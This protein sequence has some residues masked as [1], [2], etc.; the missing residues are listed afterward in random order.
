[1]SRILIVDD[2]TI[3]RRN[4]KTILQKAGHTVVAEADNG[5][6]AVREY[7]LHKPD[8]V[9][10]DIT[11]P[12]MD[13]VAA[14]RKITEEFPDANII[15]ISAIDQ[16]PMIMK[17]VEAGAKHYILKPFQPEKVLAAV[18]LVTGNLPGK[19]QA[20]IMGHRGFA[21]ASVQD[22]EPFRIENRNGA[23]IVN[24]SQYFVSD[25]V[26]L[27]VDKTNPLLQAKPLRMIFDFG[28]T[29][30]KDTSLMPLLSQLI[31]SV[32]DAGGLVLAKTSDQ[33]LANFLES[34]GIN[35]N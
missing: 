23:F 2:S 16:K 13:G 9:T 1:M 19:A 4:L 8:L 14:V 28:N 34:Q 27:L 24:I 6:Q 30:I 33:R 31:S 5:M 7:S 21:A 35:V 10:M 11:M 20:A 12:V 3:A 22:T 25:H 15:V 26:P 29:E 17:A 18:N 32:K